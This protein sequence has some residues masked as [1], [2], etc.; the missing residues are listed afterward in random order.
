MF[1][2]VTTSLVPEAQGGP[3]VFWNGLAEACSMAAALGFDAIEVFPRSAAEVE[4]SELKCALQSSGL[5][6]AGM[7]TGAG[8]VVHKLR[9]TDPDARVRHRAQDFAARI[10]DL[11][12]SFG[13]PAIL[14]S[15]QGRWEGAVTRD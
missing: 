15:M 12:A 13:A 10:V 1:S 14:G 2:A 8:W 9:L 11:A 3:F 6:L 4:A 7:G 5:R